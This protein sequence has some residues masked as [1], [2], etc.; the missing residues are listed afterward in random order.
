MQ[1]TSP[2]AFS[3]LM[4]H[5]ISWFTSQIPRKQVPSCTLTLLASSPSLLLSVLCSAYLSN[6]MSRMC[7]ELV[8][9]TN[10]VF[11]VELDLG[12]IAGGCY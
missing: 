7:Q 11:A 6:L 3:Q 12:S 5:P 1:S 9:D 10:R 8:S 2:W 4:R